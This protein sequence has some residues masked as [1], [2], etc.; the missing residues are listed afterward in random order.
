MDVDTVEHLQGRLGDE[1]Q[2]S[3]FDMSRALRLQCNFISANCDELGVGSYLEGVAED[4]ISRLD[5]FN[6]LSE[7]ADLSR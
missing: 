5:A 2:R 1:C 4:V 7:Q 3:G 6:I